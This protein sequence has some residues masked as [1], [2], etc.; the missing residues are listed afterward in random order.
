MAKF[1]QLS[2][3]KK[4]DLEF[5]STKKS[6]QNF[7]TADDMIEIYSQLCSGIPELWV[8]IIFLFLVHILVL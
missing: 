7:K 2:A 4:Y 3:G 5:K 1:T 8:A 6:G